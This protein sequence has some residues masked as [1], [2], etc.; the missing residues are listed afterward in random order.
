[1]SW[2]VLITAS[3]M[4][5]VGHEALALLEKAGCRISH[6]SLS[7]AA[8][9]DELIRLLDGMDA[10]VAG[11]DHY[12]AAYLASP[13][14]ANLKIISRWGV[15]YDAVDVPAATAAGIIVAYTPGFTDEAVADLTLG[16]LLSIAR[17][18]PA[19][20]TSM[21]EGLW[22]PKWGVDV[23][24]K[25]LGILGY[26]RIGSAVARRARGFNM[27]LIAHSPRQRPE[28]AAAGVQ[29]VSFDELL[30][31]SDFLTVHAALTPQTRGLMGEAQFRRMKKSAYLINTARGALLDED[32]LLK[33]LREG[34]IAGAA[35]DVFTEEPLPAK[36]PLRTMSN[37][38]LSP[39]QGSSALETG[40]RVSVAAVQAVLDLLG[41]RKPALVLNPE[42]FVSP[43]LRAKIRPA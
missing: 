25:T 3:A 33:A 41:G 27:R 18:I 38:L 2:K 15:G 23:P 24:G 43:R 28:A 36:H 42:V 21:R 40:E 5:K 29:Y 22:L 12:S 4:A 9:G 39:H 13:A 31:Q 7:A 20:H 6:P 34:W 10:V 26:G 30:S 32:A 35:L 14:A 8:S 1:M 19:G 37:V 17:H 11:N 16:L